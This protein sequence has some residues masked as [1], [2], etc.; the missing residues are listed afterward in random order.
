MAN[1]YLRDQFAIRDIYINKKIK[2]EFDG[3]LLKFVIDLLLSFL[4]QISYKLIS[5]PYY[6]S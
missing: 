4:M 1:I 5:N 2:I 6:F 3:D